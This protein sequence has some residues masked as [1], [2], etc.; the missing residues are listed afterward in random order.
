MAAKTL[1]LM[2]HLE[3]IYSIVVP[4][5]KSGIWMDELVSRIG[6]VMEQESPGGFELILVDDCSPDAMTW[7]AIK[8]NA[9]KYPWVR[10]FNLLFNVGQFRAIMCGLQQVRGRFVITMD[11]DLQHLPEELPKLI[12]AINEDENILCVMGRYETKQHNIFRNVGSRLVGSIMN[13]L[14]GKPPDIQTTSF[15]I[16]RK[17]LVGAITAYRTAKPQIGPLIVSTTQ[18]IKNVPVHH[19][20]RVRGLSGYQILQLI[21]ITLES[22]INASTFPL[23]FFSGI[24]FF[25]AA[26]S[27]LL[28]VMYFSRWLSGGISVAGY[29]SS[30][31]LITFFGG[32]T[33]AG[34]GVLGEYVARIITE[35]TGPEQFRIKETTG[36]GNE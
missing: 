6:V 30:I 25:C 35:I 18:K 12:R 13:R 20:P 7:P 4:V 32:M 36:E 10:G 17:E 22:I 34:I 3:P 27:V 19:V 21:N 14:Y 8:R 26:G 9:K 31:L 15:R 24:G 29:T 5:Y 2:K 11:D 28:A 23:K 16:M 33:L 1:P